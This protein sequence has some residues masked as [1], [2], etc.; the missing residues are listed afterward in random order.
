ML[1]VD[2]KKVKLIVHLFTVWTVR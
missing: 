2:F 1:S